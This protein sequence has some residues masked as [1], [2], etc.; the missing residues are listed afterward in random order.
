MTIVYEGYAMKALRRG[1]MSRATILPDAAECS[2]ATPEPAPEARSDGLL[3][4]LPETAK[5]AVKRRGHAGAPGTG[6]AGQTCKTCHHVVSR[7]G[8]V[9]SWTKCA[10]SKHRW[11]GGAGT[12]VR[13]KDPACSSWMEKSLG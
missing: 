8:G 11:T 6:P 10:L 7:R 3:M 2:P 13:K 5:R 1:L 4:M 9:R 12:D